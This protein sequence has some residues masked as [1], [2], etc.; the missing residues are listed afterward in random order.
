LI[1]S[2]RFT[3]GHGNLLSIRLN[4]DMK[5]DYSQPGLM[6]GRYLEQIDLPSAYLV[7]AVGRRLRR[8]QQLTPAAHRFASLI[9]IGRSLGI[10]S[11]IT[12]SRTI[13]D[14]RGNSFR[15]IVV[16]GVSRMTLVSKT[17]NSS[18]TSGPL[19][20]LKATTRKAVR[21]ANLGTPRAILACRAAA[22]ARE[23]RKKKETYRTT[24]ERRG[25]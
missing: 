10:F 24:K 20:H 3:A 21:E 1:C 2:A 19:F 5:G 4:A 9:P 23:S 11:K 17:K 6:P 22:L 7:Y 8:R 25:R 15:S 12:V 18:R 16:T 14:S 13:L